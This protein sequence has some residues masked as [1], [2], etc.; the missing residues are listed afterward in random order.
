[1]IDNLASIIFNSLWTITYLLINQ[2]ISNFVRRYYKHSQ[3]DLLRACATK[4]PCFRPLANCP[5]IMSLCRR[6]WG[7]LFLTVGA[8]ERK[9]RLP[10]VFDFIGETISSPWRAERSLAHRE[11][12]STDM[13]TSVKCAGHAPRTHLNAI[14]AILYV[15]RCHT[16]NH[17]PQHL[18]RRL[19]S[20][21][22]TTIRLI[23]SSSRF[24]HITSLLRQLHWLKAQERIDFK[25][26]VLVFKYVHG[27][28]PHTSLMNLVVQ[29]IP[30]LDADFARFR[31]YMWLIQAKWIMPFR[32]SISAG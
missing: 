2:S 19:Q 8:A 9:L 17:I 15:I 20:V 5:Q 12:V 14:V 23:Y 21:M 3:Y 18:L 13:H 10:D 29:L 11:T 30:K 7:R 16:G 6:W 31:Q 22:N 28:R 24:D 25:L 27:L 26:A 32:H 4:Q 1:M